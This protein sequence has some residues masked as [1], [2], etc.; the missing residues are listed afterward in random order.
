MID[1][2]EPYDVYLATEVGEVSNGG[3]SKWVD[4]WINN[5]V[6]YL[7]VKPVLIIEIEQDE[8]WM[9]YVTQFITPINRPGA[10]WEWEYCYR[11]LPITNYFSLPDRRCVDMLIKH[12]RKFHIMSY[13]IPIMMIGNQNNLTPKQ[14]RDTYD[15]EIDSLCVHS[16][17]RETLPVQQK[18]MKFGKQDLKYQQISIDFQELLIKEAKETIWIGTEDEDGFDYT[19]SNYY[20]FQHNLPATDSN[21]V[22]FPA[23]CEARKNLQFLKNVDSIIFTKEASMLSYLSRVKTKFTLPKTKLEEY[24]VEKIHDFYMSQEWGISHSCFVD[25]P[26]GYSILQSIDYGKLPILSNNWCEEMEYPF[27]ASTR[28]QFEKQVANI[29]NLSLEDRNNYL[30]KLRDYLSKYSSVEKWRDDFLSVYNKDG[31]QV[32]LPTNISPSKSV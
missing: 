23:R 14:M 15:R 18:I 9:E 2:T 28:I 20:E 10:E 16:R 7:V 25:E 30:G 13:P 4:D 32:W 6:P 11:T 8:F 3:I 29:S 26:F 19:I 31:D 22:G 21:V 17:E 12:A 24:R 1:L 5:V 27:R